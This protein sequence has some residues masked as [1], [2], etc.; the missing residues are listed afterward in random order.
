M[1][2]CGYVNSKQSIANG[3]MEKFLCRYSCR[4]TFNYFIR[5][6]ALQGNVDGVINILEEMK[7]KGIPA[8]DFTYN[9]LILAFAND[10]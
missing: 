3:H 9:N 10:G 8:S 2:K 7:S 4:A 5:A 6:F 1:E